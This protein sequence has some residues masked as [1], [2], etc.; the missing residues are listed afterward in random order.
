[1]VDHDAHEKAN[2]SRVSSG[3]NAN[4]FYPKPI[5]LS[6]MTLE[7][8]ILNVAERMAGMKNNVINKKFIKF[9]LLKIVKL[10]K[11]LSLLF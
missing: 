3:T 1:M 7:K 10:I 4:D 2:Q 9:T 5:D 6:N 8:E 11:L